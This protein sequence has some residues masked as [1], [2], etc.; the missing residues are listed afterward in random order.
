MRGASSVICSARQRWIVV[1]LIGRG[2]EIL[3]FGLPIG[4]STATSY[5]AWRVFQNDDVSFVLG[6]DGLVLFC[7]NCSWASG[8]EKLGGCR[9]VPPMAGVNLSGGS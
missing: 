6:T 4:Q 1:M 5:I 2:R 9:V 3:C 7:A 8:F